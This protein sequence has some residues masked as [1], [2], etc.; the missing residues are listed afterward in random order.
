M[1]PYQYEN[2]AAAVYHDKKRGP[3]FGINEFYSEEPFNGE[4]K[5]GCAT[6]Y[7]FYGISYKYLAFR[8]EMF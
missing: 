1:Y 3:S 7:N 5:C 6:E 2:G 4:N 8:T